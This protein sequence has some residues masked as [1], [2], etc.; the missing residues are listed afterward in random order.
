MDEVFYDHET[1]GRPSALLDCHVFKRFC[2][3]SLKF[4]LVTTIANGLLLKNTSSAFYSV[5]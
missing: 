5:F 4:L 1:N 3:V 2:L